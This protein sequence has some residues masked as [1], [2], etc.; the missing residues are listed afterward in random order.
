MMRVAA[1]V[2]R[3]RAFELRAM[4]IGSEL[5]E[6]PLLPNERR[7]SPRVLQ[8]FASARRRKHVAS[9]LDVSEM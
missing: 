2:C 6:A 9:D 3:L 8:D 5:M 4:R 1:G 7:E